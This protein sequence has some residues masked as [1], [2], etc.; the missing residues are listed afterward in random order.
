MGQYS[1][2]ASGDVLSAIIGNGR[3]LLFF[4]MQGFEKVSFEQ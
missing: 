4:A 3:P 1:A 2:Y